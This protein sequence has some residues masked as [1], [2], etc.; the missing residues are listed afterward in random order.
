MSVLALEPGART[1]LLH[2]VDEDDKRVLCAWLVNLTVRAPAVSRTYDV[3]VR[4]GEPAS[5]RIVYHNPWARPQTFVV[6]S[7]SPSVVAV[8]NERLDVAA[9]GSAFIHLWFAPCAS[10][11]RRDS[12]VLV[13]DAGGRSEDCLLIRVESSM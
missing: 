1:A 5:K 6:R 7:S 11:C 2:A 13:G 4:V 9:N 3:L 12:Y 8:R 10:P